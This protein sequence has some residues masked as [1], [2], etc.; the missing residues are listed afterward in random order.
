MNIPSDLIEKTRQIC[1]SYTNLSE[2]DIEIII[3]KSLMLQTIADIAAG[4]AFIDCLGKDQQ[5]MVVIAEAFPETTHSLYKNSILGKRIYQ[6]KEPAV[7][8]AY[9]TESP[10]LLHRAV[11]DGSHVKQNVTPI[12]NAQNKTIGVLILEQDITLQVKQENEIIVLSE[13]TK[14][15]NR[16][17]WDII[18][19]EEQILPDFIHE[20]LI[21]LGKDGLILYANNYALSII[22]TYGNLNGRNVINRPINEVLSFI[23]ES[24]YTHDRMVQR[25]IN[26]LQ[27][28]YRL[29]AICLK[30]GESD[31]RRVLLNL[32]DITD[33]RDKE[34]QLMVKSAVIQEIHHRVKNNLQ[35]IASLLR[36]QLRKEI[37]DDPRIFY[38]ESMNRIM[39]IATIHEELS[40]SGIEKV[41]MNVVIHKLSNMFYY[42]IEELDCQIEIKLEIEEILLEANQAFSLAL[43]LTELIQNCLKHAFSGLITGIITVRLYRNQNLY[44]LTVMDNGIGIRQDHPKDHLG[45]EI[46]RNLTLH[47]LN[48]SFSI[49]SNP[50]V[51]PG[52]CAHLTFPLKNEVE[53]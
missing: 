30:E 50:K 29:R 26:Y 40:Y 10:S 14:K 23:M 18:S 20:A 47:D 53:K 35:T 43:V 5:T 46:V 21:L 3:N 41:N 22:E 39:S 44:D 4:D 34:R 51:I 42:N 12:L 32:Y 37:P 36:M 15:I 28:V 19:N 49:D 6:P 8:R 33:L 25:E 24:D 31:D 9:H 2:N 7:Y 27:K 13:A 1:K 52:T 16:T 17:F 45:L 38:Q 48:G 11:Y